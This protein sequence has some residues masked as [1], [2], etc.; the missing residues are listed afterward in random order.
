MTIK[1]LSN[2]NHKEV[3]KLFGDQVE[4]YYFLINDLV[5]QN[6]QNVYGEYEN[7]HLVSI[8]LNQFN[9]VTYYSPFDRDVTTYSEILQILPYQ[10][11]TGPSKLITKFEP[12]IRAKEDTLSYMGVVKNI[13]AKRRFP[14]LDIKIVQTDEEIGQQFDLFRLTAEFVSTLPESKSDYIR[15]E[16]ERLK[17]TSDRTV[18]L[19]VKNKM[20][21]TAATIKEGVNSAIIIGVCTDPSCRG[22]GYGTDVLIGMFEQLLKEGKYPYLFYNNPAARRV[23]RNLGMTEVCEWRVIKI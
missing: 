6:Y 16:K 20:V 14:N 12:L 15:M 17:T 4:N 10:K 3:L 19:S 7:E 9:N 22:M 8:L 5:N 18:Y 2:S 23:Y 13:T 11:L 1:Q 21:A